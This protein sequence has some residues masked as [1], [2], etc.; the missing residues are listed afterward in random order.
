MMDGEGTNV[1]M[2][3]LDRVTHADRL[4]G[5]AEELAAKADALLDVEEWEESEG[6]GEIYNVTATAELYVNLAYSYLYS[7]EVR[8][9][10]H[11]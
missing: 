5:R 3:N 9:M 6:P 1:N 4:L 8:K 10:I 7:V 11:G 2:S